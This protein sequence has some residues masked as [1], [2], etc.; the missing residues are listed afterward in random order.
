MLPR[1]LTST[2]SATGMPGTMTTTAT[3]GTYEGALSRPFGS[4][5]IGGTRYIPN[6][7]MA[8]SATPVRVICYNCLCAAVENP[9]RFSLFCLL[10]CTIHCYAVLHCTIFI[11]NAQLRHSAIFAK[12]IFFFACCQIVIGYH[13]AILCRH[14][15]T[16]SCTYLEDGWFTDL[17]TV[18]DPSRRIP[19]LKWIRN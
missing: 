14:G 17:Q 9:P 19:S 7:T 13:L 12:Q 10:H 11:D 3:T 8:S 5:T 18:Q 6:T 15:N 16:G 1:Y 2:T 4:T